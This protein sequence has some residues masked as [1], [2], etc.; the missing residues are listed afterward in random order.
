[1]D[2]TLV[3]AYNDVDLCLNA[4]RLGHVN[5]VS[6]HIRFVH[7]ES[8]TRGFD[9]T[10]DQAAR[11]AEEAKRLLQK[12]GAALQTDPF[13]NVNLSRKAENL[14]LNGEMP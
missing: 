11:L 4:L 7:H 12:W 13:Y 6:P 3:V 2:E 9:T 5:V 14:S 8:I 1:M 10:P